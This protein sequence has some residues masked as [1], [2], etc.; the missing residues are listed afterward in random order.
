LRD[1]LKNVPTGSHI[2]D[3]GSASGGNTLLMTQ[4]GYKVTS[5]EFSDL[6]VEIQKAKGLDVFKADAREVPFGDNTFDACICLDVLEH[7]VE[8]WKVVSEISRT[9]RP[10][11][12]CLISV[13]EDMS[14]WSQHDVSVGHVRRYSK[15]EIKRLLISN[16]L[17]IDS[18]RSFNTL[19]KP[20]VRL[21]RKFSTGSDLAELPKVVNET[22]FKLSRIDYA[23]NKSS[24]SGM[25]IWI[26]ASNTSIE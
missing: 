24:W 25:T 23:L 21:K 7:I 20:L 3:L 10:L 26:A 15:S 19:L 6:G 11:G 12:K 2:L 8:D 4:L 1:W 22:L 9:V 16:R 14:L 5:L 17:E 13:P 18:I